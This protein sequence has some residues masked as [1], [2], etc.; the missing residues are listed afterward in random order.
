[1]TAAR[2]ADV[3]PTQPDLSPGP[4]AQRWG[5]TIDLDTPSPSARLVTS[6]LDALWRARGTDLILTAGSP[7][8]LRVDGTVQAMA[9]QPALRP[10]ETSAIADLLVGPDLSRRFAAD[11]QI[12]FAFGWKDRARLRGNAYRQQGSVAIAL[13][14]M[15]AQIPDMTELQLPSVCHEWVRLPRGFVLVTGPTGSGKST[16]LAAML[17]HINAHRPL[18]VVTIEDPIEYVHT[19]KRSVISQ[20]EV[21]TD[22]HSFGDA[23]RACLREDPDVLLIGEMRDPESIQAALTIAETGHLV[24]ASLHTN[25]AAQTLDR[26]IDVFPT[27]RQPQVRLQLAHTLAGILHQL[28]IPKVGGGRVAAFDILAGTMAVRNLIREGKTRQIRNAIVT[29]R[30][31]GMCTLEDSLNSLIAAGTVSYEEAILCSLHQEEIRPLEPSSSRD[32]QGFVRRSRSAGRP[33]H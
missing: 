22:T 5:S 32:P 25:D 16:T 12:D 3:D 21:G 20:R 29:G 7:P 18:H 17:G 1:M 30:S 19:P 26:I 14:M 8:A 28:L 23:L 27:D 15:P 4:G 9:D 13:R 24:F 31:D 6:Y 2:V 10:D 33:H 11:K